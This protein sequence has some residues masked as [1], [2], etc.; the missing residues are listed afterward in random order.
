L[1]LSNRLFVYSHADRKKGERLE[2]KIKVERL[3]G[4]GWGL[5]NKGCTTYVCNLFITLCLLPRN[6]MFDF[7]HEC[8][9]CE[10]TDI[11]V[12]MQLTAR[13]PPVNS[14]MKMARI[15]RIRVAGT[16]FPLF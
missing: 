16:Y 8:I 12:L 9:P 14:F 2:K 13:N 7:P 11:S 10:R 1:Y 3:G 6:S 15:A 5:G 4:G